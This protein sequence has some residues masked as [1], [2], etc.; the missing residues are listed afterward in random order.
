MEKTEPQD[1]DV[2]ENLVS[3]STN[4]KLRKTI[5][6]LKHLSMKNKE[7]KE[8]RK[9]KTNAFKNSTQVTSLSKWAV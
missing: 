8:Y 3:E 1:K 5:N 4:D 9:P 7:H 6:S 2:V